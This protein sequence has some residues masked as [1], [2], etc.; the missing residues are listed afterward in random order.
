MAQSIRE[1]AVL[2]VDDCL[3]DQLLVQEAAR[4]AQ[5]RLVFIPIGTF[6][7]A[8]AYLA[9]TGPF[10]DRDQFPVP[11]LLLADW[12]LDACQTGLDLLRWVRAREELSSL[13]VVMYS[14]TAGQEQIRECYLCGSNHF[15][16]KAA[17]FSRMVPILN[18]LQQWLDSTP[19]RSDLLQQLPEYRPPPGDVII[20]DHLAVPSSQLRAP[21]FPDRAERLEKPK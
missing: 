3:N 10:A 2:H 5:S 12:K 16:F 8:V 15:L 21:L 13:P 14:G 19:P 1:Y 4:L 18:A 7:S 9:G 20:G 11:D 6:G 17:E